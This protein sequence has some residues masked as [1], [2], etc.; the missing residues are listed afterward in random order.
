MHANRNKYLVKRYF[1]DLW[2]RGDLAAAD[3]ILAPE[4]GNACGSAMPGR[5]AVKLY[6][7]GYREA[8]PR[9]RFTIVG[10]AAQGDTVAVCWV[11]RGTHRDGW[12]D[13]KE[14]PTTGLTVFRIVGERIVEGW[15]TVSDSPVVTRLGVTGPAPEEQI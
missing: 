1:H 5:E 6:V 4:F 8:F 9:T 2:N 3:E 11:S 7:V 10:M 15:A 12:L 13:G 14:K